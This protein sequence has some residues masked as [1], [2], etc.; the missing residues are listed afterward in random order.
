MQFV[1]WPQ[2]S[3]KQYYQ[4]AEGWSLEFTPNQRILLTTLGISVKVDYLNDYTLVENYLHGYQV[5]IETLE[6]IDL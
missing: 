5:K 3:I 6:Q 1:L 2:Q 4:F